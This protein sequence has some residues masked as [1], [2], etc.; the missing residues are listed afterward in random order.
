MSKGHK[1]SKLFKLKE[2]LTVLDAA[3]HLSV[4]FGEEVTEA[5]V[6]RLALD[7]HLKLSVNFVNHTV[8]KKGRIV[9]WEETE[10]FRG[11]P[12]IKLGTKNNKNTICS[13]SAIYETA[14]ELLRKNLPN[15][16]KVDIPND[17]RLLTARLYPKLEVLFEKISKYE[18]DGLKKEVIEKEISSEIQSL[19]KIVDEIAD[20]L[21]GTEKEYIEHQ[22]ELITNKEMPRQL[23]ILLDKMS[24][25]DRVKEK[26]FQQTCFISSI[27][28]DNERYLNLEKK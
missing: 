21:S 22:S 3:K 12:I 26:L 1:L 5:D 18:K 20:E 14:A 10:W 16:K 2:W 19:K 27:N 24:I 28:I 25:P 8:A 15:E 9:S 11:P 4:V 7:G 17:I 23:H 13:I 6:L